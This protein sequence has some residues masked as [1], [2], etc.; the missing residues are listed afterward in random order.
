MLIIIPSLFWRISV[1]TKQQMKFVFFL[2]AG[3]LT[4]HIMRVGRHPLYKV[5][6]FDE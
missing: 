2:N 5:L 6:R 1:R 4:K 3:M